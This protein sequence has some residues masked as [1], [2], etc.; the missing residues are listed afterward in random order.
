MNLQDLIL[1]AD[2]AATDAAKKALAPAPLD[3]AEVERIIASLPEK[4]AAAKKENPGADG[5]VLYDGT[6]PKVK[7]IALAVCEALSPVVDSQTTNGGEYHFV[8]VVF[9]DL[10]RTA[11]SI[12]RTTWLESV[13][14]AWTGPTA[15]L[16][17]STGSSLTFAYG[18]IIHIAI[19]DVARKPADVV[20]EAAKALRMPSWTV[21]TLGE[22]WG[23]RMGS[24]EESS[25]SALH[26]R[27][28]DT[29]YRAV[30]CIHFSSAHFGDW[31]I[32]LDDARDLSAKELCDQAA[33]ALKIGWTWA[34]SEV[35]AIGGNGVTVTPAV[36]AAKAAPVLSKWDKK[37]AAK[38]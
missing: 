19:V 33:E 32:D 23:V 36:L 5:F 3:P 37:A 34:P 7:R 38:K 16:Y 18:D 26:G 30:E 14:A 20:A 17:N 9:A 6:G 24:E 2:D 1:A 22:A 13:T 31:Y 25:V 15:P 21:A 28:V 8:R 35:I 27:Y 29:L 12:R 11:Q 4:A 10:E